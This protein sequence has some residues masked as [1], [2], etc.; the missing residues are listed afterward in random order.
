MTAKER[1]TIH[2][3]WEASL[4]HRKA[5]VSELRHNLTLDSETREHLADVSEGLLIT[6][7][8]LESL[9]KSAK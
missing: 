1:D 9:L 2:S 6:I 3:C 5:L 7:S 8:K 4:I